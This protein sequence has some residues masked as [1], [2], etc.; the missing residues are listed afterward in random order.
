LLAEG[1]V[2][3][4]VGSGAFRNVPKQIKDLSLIEWDADSHQILAKKHHDAT[5]LASIE[6]MLES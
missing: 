1:S 6:E 5:L 2:A 3:S 4:K